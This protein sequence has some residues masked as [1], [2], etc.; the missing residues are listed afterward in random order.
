MNN[1]TEK[2][3]SP[4]YIRVFVNRNIFNLWGGQIVSQTGDSIYEIALLWIL[5]EMTGS[6]SETGLIAM[7]GYLPALLFGLFSGALV[8]RFDRRRLMLVADM[9]RFLLV[10]MIPVLYFTGVL[11]GLLLG[12]FTFLIATFNTL[13]NPAR[14][15]LVGQLA[16]V[17]QRFT[18]NAMI[19][20]S[21]QYAAFFGPALAGILL[22]LV[23]EIH[24]FTVDAF[25]FLLSFVFIWRITVR[26][27]ETS[28][29]AQAASSR[30]LL[31]GGWRDVLEGLRYARQDRRILALLLITAANN[32][33]LMGPA[34]VGAPIFVRE[35]LRGG[36]ESYAFVQ[37]AYA[38]GM[39]AATFALNRYGRRFR[40]SHLILWG[41]IVDGL[42][43]IPLLWVDTFA[44]MF[45]TIAIHALALPMIIISRPTLI[46]GIVPEE[47]QGRI[48]GMIS[49]S[50]F[51]FTAISIALTGLLAEIISIN[52]LY[53]LM[54]TMA[55]SIGIIGWFVKD[56]RE[57]EGVGQQ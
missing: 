46:Q 25:T 41:M 40:N 8:D 21:W 51:G 6:N 33:F 35:I 2:V 20:T 11:S 31:A 22:A 29:A 39:I 12:V 43:F 44:G 52:I 15:A 23:G 3:R 30:L 54:G 26:R 13:F 55:A 34:I 28:Q 10:L 53:A 24:L 57:S 42:T 7:S 4:W 50:V 14:D 18:A 16:T 48:F 47:M 1:T 27:G 56:F 37:I 17:Q 19:Q 38:I 36:A 45:V 5:L 32:L 9:A 49:V